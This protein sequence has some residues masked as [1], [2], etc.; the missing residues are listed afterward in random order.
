VER[1]PLWLREGRRQLR[2]EAK[3]S[4][5]G[6]KQRAEAKALATGR[7]VVTA[8]LVV[9]AARE[10]DGRAAGRR[11]DRRSHLVVVLMPVAPLAGAGAWLVTS[12]RAT[13]ASVAIALVAGAAIGNGGGGGNG[14][15]HDEEPARVML[16][17]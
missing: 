11:G 2:V 4:R 12:S 14:G 7:G 5:A 10:R 6:I 3:R 15:R 16:P 13:A 8:E 17:V 1:W 9:D